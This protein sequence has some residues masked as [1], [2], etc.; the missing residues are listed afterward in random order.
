MRNLFGV[1]IILAQVGCAEKGTN[2]TTTAP[3]KVKKASVPKAPTTPKMIKANLGARFAAVPQTTMAQFE[4]LL[5]DLKKVKEPIHLSKF[6]TRRFT[7]S[8]LTK[9]PDWDHE[10]KNIRVLEVR[11][12]RLLVIFVELKAVPSKEEI[13]AK[14]REARERHQA[15][16]GEEAEPY[17]KGTL[18]AIH[19]KRGV[20]GFNVLASEMQSSSMFAGEPKVIFS[21]YFKETGTFLVSFYDASEDQDGSGND[22][23]I[24]EAGT[25]L[26]AYSLDD[27]QIKKQVHF[28]DGSMKGLSG[29]KESEH[30][31]LSWKKG[32]NT[33]SVYLIQKYLKVKRQVNT[34]ENLD[35]PPYWRCST[36]YKVTAI[37]LTGHKWKTLTKKEATALKDKEPLLQD[38]PEDSEGEKSSPNK[39][40]MCSIK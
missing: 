32:K 15:G 23:Q 28:T 11:K 9:K 26:A 21:P 17:E 34:G 16:A 30:V 37:P 13:E 2:N 33:K 10:K 38:L 39:P 25:S 35:A 22:G 36:N 40:K 8:A 7:T 1:L 27:N 12:G 19:L 5:S 24:Q 18:I 31:A 20:N 6:I 14:K 4:G 29:L 3:S